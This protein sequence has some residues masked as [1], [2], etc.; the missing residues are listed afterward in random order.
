[1]GASTAFLYIKGSQLWIQALPNVV[2]VSAVM[3]RDRK[4]YDNLGRF[5]SIR[6][7]LH[8]IR[9]SSRRDRWS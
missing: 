1:M 2:P 6:Y 8:R 9:H 3:I 5:L 4:R 7:T